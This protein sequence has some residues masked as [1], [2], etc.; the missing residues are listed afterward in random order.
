MNSILTGIKSNKVYIYFAYGRIL[1]PIGYEITP[2][3]PLDAY[4]K[5][6]DI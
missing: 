4:K 5:L 6:E 2:L 1:C 3:I